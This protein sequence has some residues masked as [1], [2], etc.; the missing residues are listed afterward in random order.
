MPCSF[1]A[2]PARALVLVAHVRLSATTCPPLRWLHRVHLF[3]V[4]V[5]TFVNQL[6]AKQVVTHPHEHQIKIAFSI[7]NHTTV[8]KLGRFTLDPDE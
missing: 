7:L 8:F 2:V 4:F 1:C 6:A 5:C 3:V